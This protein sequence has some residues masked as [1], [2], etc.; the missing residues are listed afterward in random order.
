MLALI[1]VAPAWASTDSLTLSVAPGANDQPSGMSTTASWTLANPSDSYTVAVHYARGGTC[2][3]DPASDPGTA[4]P[5][6]DGTDPGGSALKT[7]Q[8]QLLPGSWILCGWLIDN[9]LGQSVTA[10]AQLS[11]TVASAD[12]LALSVSPAPVQG[13]MITIDATGINYDSG[14]VLA[15][16]Q[17]AGP[18]G[19]GASPQID[20]GTEVISDVPPGATGH[21]AADLSDTSI[22]SPGTWRLCEWLTDQATGTVPAASRSSRCPPSAPSSR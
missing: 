5:S 13:R 14:A 10:T 22:F 19:C 2:A 18:G 7:G 6:L 3:P 8:D 4:L 11:V 17:A 1:A 12:T 15:L 16:H 9:N 21:Y 20:P